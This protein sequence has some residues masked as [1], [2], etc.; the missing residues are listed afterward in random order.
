M[1][2]NDSYIGM[3]AYHQTNHMP[4]NGASSIVLPGQTKGF[5]IYNHPNN[6]ISH[7]LLPK[8]DTSFTGLESQIAQLW[9]TS[10]DSYVSTDEVWKFNGNT[11]SDYSSLSSASVS[12]E[13]HRS[14][15]FFN[16]ASQVCHLI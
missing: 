4:K 15:A 3:N 2:S 1:F 9:K 5:A 13:D 6:K 14:E 12:P 10:S 7:S 11:I 8:N 16:V